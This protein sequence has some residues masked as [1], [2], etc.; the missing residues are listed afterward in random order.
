M[1]P[2][3]TRYAVT[4]QILCYVYGSSPYVDDAF[5]GVLWDA[6][7]LLGL[8][9]LQDACL[10]HI[11]EA[12]SVTNAVYFANFAAAVGLE[13]LRESCLALIATHARNVVAAHGFC[14]LGASSLDALLGDD[15]LDLPE[16]HVFRTMLA[17]ASFQ[18]GVSGVDHVIL[19]ENAEKDEDEAA[20][21]FDFAAP[22]AVADPLPEDQRVAIAAL[23]LPLAHR[24]RVLL[25]DPQ[26]VLDQ[27]LPLRVL[28]SD[29]VEVFSAGGGD[30]TGAVGSGGDSYARPRRGTQTFQ[31]STLLEVGQQAQINEWYGT[32]G[33]KWRLL[34]RASRD[35]FRAAAFHGACGHRRPTVCVALG[36]AK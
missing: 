7:R 3:H 1:L 24:L 16:A 36:P 6:A 31:E 22:P 18:A 5:V 21:G 30:T 17:W 34:F 9:P 10:H 4:P 12:L 2:P 19:P 25:L 14:H 35:G 8:Q 27:V 13:E 28:P 20:F 11:Q 26:F 33:Q 32:P 15:A 29:L 23:L